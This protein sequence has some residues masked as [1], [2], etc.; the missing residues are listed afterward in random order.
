MRIGKFTPYQMCSIQIQTHEQ[1]RW[2]RV[3]VIYSGMMDMVVAGADTEEIRGDEGQRRTA[4]GGRYAGM[5][6]R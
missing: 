3:D 2:V 4:N 5:T 6:E 1:L